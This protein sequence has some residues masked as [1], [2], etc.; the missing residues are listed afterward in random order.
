MSRVSSAMR[1]DITLQWRQGFYYVCVFAA[2]AWVVFLSQFSKETLQYFLP[3]FLLLSMNITT[4]FFVAGLVLFEKGEGVLEGL[5]VT[6]LQTKEYLTSKTATLT[7][8]ALVENVLIIVLVYGF[9]FEL[10]PIIA[11]LVST[12]VIYVLIGFVV[13]ARYDSINEYLMPA[14]LFVGILQLPWIGYFELW[15]PQIFYVFPTQAPLLLLK[16]GF[17]SIETWQIVYAV[18]CSVVWVAIFYVLA[19][20]SF[21][22][23]VIKTRGV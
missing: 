17:Q 7:L 19:H 1:W 8:L 23:F 20:K 14:S 4:Y 5:V 3:P 12:A 22:K 11:G 10:L 9:A 13:V 16:W 18:V 6:P 2:I 21:Q 15:N